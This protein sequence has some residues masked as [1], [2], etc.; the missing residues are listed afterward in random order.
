METHC[1]Q[2]VSIRRILERT[3]ENYVSYALNEQAYL[4]NKKKFEKVDLADLKKSY[5]ELNI[6]HLTV[7]TQYDDPKDWYIISEERR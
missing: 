2:E 6:T 1:P 5:P 4:N 3:K 7:D